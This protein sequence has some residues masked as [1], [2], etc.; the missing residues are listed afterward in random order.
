MTKDQYYEMCE[1]LGTKPVESE[2][3][4]EYHDLPYE[5]QTTVEIC[6]ILQDSW[7]TFNGNYLGKN[8]SNVKDL[9]DIYEIPLPDQKL[10][11]EYLLFIDRLRKDIVNSKKPQGSTKP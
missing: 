4:V 7:D 5:I 6:N 8:Y 2:I 9:F 11:Y 1:A 10:I 3:P